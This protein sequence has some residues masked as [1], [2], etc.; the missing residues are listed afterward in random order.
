MHVN[1]RSLFFMQHYLVTDILQFTIN[2]YGLSIFTYANNVFQFK[3]TLV[4]FFISKMNRRAMICLYQRP[5]FSTQ[6]RH[7]SEASLIRLR[8]HKLFPYFLNI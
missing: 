4:Y 5:I 6:K 8:T 1:I 2:L 7:F 3:P